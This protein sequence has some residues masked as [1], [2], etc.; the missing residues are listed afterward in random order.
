M[1]IDPSGY[2]TDAQTGAPIREAAVTLYRVPSALPD[3][4]TTTRECRTID[5]R[6]GGI[7]G[8]W[9]LLPSA[10][11][12]LGLFE[13]P[14]FLPAAIDPP[15]NPQRTDEAGHYGWDVIRGCWYVKV[16]ALGYFSKYSAVV[17]VPPEVTD[18]DI[19]LEP[20]KQV[21]LPAVLK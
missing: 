6:P 2:V 9:D 16:E 11:P 5:T 15:I 7:T 8:T 13:E 21:Y 20:W 1:L 19:V 17:G 4:R 3:T 18:L 12:D 10:T 14:A